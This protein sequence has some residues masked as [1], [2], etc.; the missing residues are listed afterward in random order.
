MEIVTMK[1]E[2]VFRNKLIGF[3][4]VFSLEKFPSWSGAKRNGTELGF[5]ELSR[6][7]WVE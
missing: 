3:T 6:A 1:F 5:S 4:E 7:I 2:G